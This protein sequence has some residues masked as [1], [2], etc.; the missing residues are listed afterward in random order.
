[1]NILFLLSVVEIVLVVFFTVG[2]FI[3]GASWKPKITAD[4]KK[5]ALKEKH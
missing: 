4:N 1:M 5:V 2:F 3:L